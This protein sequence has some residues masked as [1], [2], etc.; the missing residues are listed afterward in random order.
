M[1]KRWLNEKD[2]DGKLIPD[3]QGDYTL[4]IE[5]NAGK[6]VS[7]F[8]GKSMETVVEDLAD[9]Q[10]HANRQLGRLLKPDRERP[11]PLQHA[12]RKLDD[13]DKLRLSTEIT[14][15]NRVVDAVT[16]IV[17]AV[18]GAP[19]SAVAA[20]VASMDQKE[21]DEYY[22][23][24]AEAFMADYPDYYRVPQ[25]A[26]ALNAELKARGLVLSRINL[27]IVYEAL[28]DEGKMIMEPLGDGTPPSEEAPPSNTTPKPR[29]ISSGLRNSDA[30]ASRPAPT[31]KKPL[32]T[33]ADLE[34]M[35]RAEYNERL[36]DPAFRRAVDALT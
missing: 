3:E 19:P 6:R 28:R 10:V 35:S 11:A 25:N 26:E 13:A 20:R 8:K 27:S 33:K 23:A 12:P 29:S 9:A 21:A 24:E 2:N 14:D 31:P 5:N 34:R 22:L 1:Q 36:R 17:T 4:V 7:T 18:Q 15:P 16:E 32:V 30:S